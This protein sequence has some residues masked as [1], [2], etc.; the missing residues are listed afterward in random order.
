MF[1]TWKS[2]LLGLGLS[3]SGLGSTVSAQEFFLGI[4]SGR[5]PGQGTRVAAAWG[6]PAYGYA[7]PAVVPV[8]VPDPYLYR[9]SIAVA[10]PRSSV[11]VVE[12]GRAVIPYRV[13]PR[14]VVL[15]LE[16]QRLNLVRDPYRWDG[17][18]WGEYPLQTVPVRRNGC[19]REDVGE[20]IAPRHRRGDYIYA[21]SQDTIIE[22]P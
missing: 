5:G 15:P 8:A 7:V 1:R 14:P 11:L 9:R 19:D 4:S 2:V 12:P 3:V 17:S 22:L 10:V 21:R 13:A 6:I 20:W 16:S 18:Q